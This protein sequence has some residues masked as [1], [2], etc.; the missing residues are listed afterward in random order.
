MNFPCYRVQYISPETCNIR[1][2]A[3]NIYA[4]VV[5]GNNINSEMIFKDL[6]ICVALDF[7]E[8]CPF[9]FC[10]GPILVMKDPEF[11]VASFLV[12]IKPA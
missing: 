12:Q 4:Q 6:D 11:R 7:A 5:L 9:Y 8:Q 1:G 2:P 3:V 10:P